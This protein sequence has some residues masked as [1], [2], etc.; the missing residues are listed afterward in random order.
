[1]PEW[2]IDLLII[3]A[4]IAVVH[5]VLLTGVAY[6]VY[7]E[8]RISGFVQNRYGPNRVGPEG[9][10]QPLVD[11]IKLLMKEDIVPEKANRRIHA[12][13]PG[14]SIVVAL[15]TFAVIPFGDKIEL[16]GRTIQ[17]Q[18]ANVN[19]GILYILALLSLGVYGITLSGWSS[20]SKYSLLGGLRSSAQ[21]ISY[22]LSMGIAVLGIIIMTGTLELN[23]IVELQYGWKWNIILQPVGFII[24]L[25]ASFAETNRAPFDLPEAEQ[26]LVGGYHTE[27]SSMK[28]AMFFLAE[29]AAMIVASAVI[30]TLYLGGWQFPY[31]Q[32]FGLPA[33]VTSILQVLTFSI[34]VVALVFF[35][36]WVRWTIP[37]F[38]YDQLMDLGWKVMLPLALLNLFVTG[39]VV[40]LLN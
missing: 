7:A 15:S 20:N 13:A 10:L 30:T 4:K 37:R 39:L 29:Y 1:M 28:F 22:E 11:V 14:I 34:K 21:M 9:L 17:L 23:K 24:F 19:I 36:I 12:M 18:I 40:L 32:D 33:I 5:G 2:L 6:S 8:R 26:E 31:L 25:V 3:L 27:Y 38:R 35:F 16:F